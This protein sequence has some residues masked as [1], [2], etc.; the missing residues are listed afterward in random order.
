[1]LDS[2]HDI[3]PW[4]QGT[5]T[6]GLWEPHGDLSQEVDVAPSFLSVQVKATADGCEIAVKPLDVDMPDTKTLPGPLGT[7]VRTSLRFRSV[8]RRSGEVTLAAETE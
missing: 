5:K 4:R 6:L 8:S 3:P 7:S 1:L 2:F